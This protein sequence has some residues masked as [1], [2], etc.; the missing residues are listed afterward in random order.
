VPPGT[1]RMTASRPLVVGT[2]GHIDHGK[3]RLVR[4][5]T[6]IDPDRLKEE[7]ERGI[8]IDLGFAHLALD[9]GT[10]IG[11]VD[12]P[13]H[14]RF[15]KNMLAGVGGIDLVLLVIAADESIK[16]Q[17]REHFDICRLLRIPRGIVVLTKSDLVDGEML[18]LVRMEARE[19]VA[20]SFLEDAPV[21]AVSAVSGDGLGSL[22]TALGEAARDLPGRAVTGLPR[23]PVD[24]AFT[25]RGFG[26]VVT[27]TLLTGSLHEGREAVLLPR[28]LPVR[29]RGLQ[30]HGETV[31]RA[32]PG[33]RVAA[34]L[35]GV[36]AGSIERG[37]LLTERGGLEPTRLLDVRLEYLPSAGAALKDLARVS[38]HVLTAETPARVKLV[39]EAPV[40]PGAAATAQLRTARPVVVMP[41]DRFILRRPSPAMTIA[42]GTVLHN[43]PPK[44]RGHGEGPVTR[45]ERLATASPVE[46]LRI[47]VDEAG[48]GGID[49]LTLRARTGM[50]T[51][52]VEKLLAADA[53]TGVVLALPSTPRRFI[54]RATAES[55]EGSVIGV[56]R[57]FHAREPLLEGLPREEL[58]TRVFANSHP[59][60]FRGLVADLE[61]R[62]I[63]RSARDKVALATHQVELDPEQTRVTDALDTAFRTAGANPPDLAEAAK[64]VGGDVRRIEKLVHLLLAR[65]RLVRIPDGKIFHS[66]A[67]EDLKRRLWTWR[68]RSDTI[69]IGAFK[70]L[71]GT[72]RKN[73]IPLLEYL[74]QIQVT[75]REGGVRRIMPAPVA[76]EGSDTTS[77]GGD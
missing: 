38:L 67:I 48:P 68:E 44:L 41:G 32:L 19:F 73:A 45:Y 33:Q 21:V 40:E 11:F 20:G 64:A 62:G 39:S 15:V 63:L 52:A 25:I 22:K 76:A 6:G 10:R 56:L 42:G 17:T 75:R 27:G 31:A 26:T 5:L 43:A 70:D 29:I 65:G 9:D 72:S 1:S 30:V 54:G 53:A 7:Q 57:E 58:R 4:A 13:G 50:E 49:S 14:E 59:E 71:S 36:E 74:D 37:D 16:P 3:S 12:V 28:G 23:L 47:L 24:R 69:E 8:T 2:A 18:E 77:P 61:T 60:V 51:A 46:L 66:S 55:L 34:N 35:Q